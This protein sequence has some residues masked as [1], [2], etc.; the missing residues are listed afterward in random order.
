VIK[1]YD[2]S[3]LVKQAK[4][5]DFGAFEQLVN[6]HETRVYTV[7]MNILRQRQD[8]EDVVQTALLKALE[9]LDGFREEAA[10]STWVR[11]IAVNEALKVL[12][13]RRGQRTVSM[14]KGA[15]ENEE[16]RIPHPGYVACWRGNPAEIVERKNLR[17]ILD[18]AI[19]ALPEK[20]R[21]VFVLRDV[22]GMSVRETAEILGISEPNVKVRLLR[23]RLALR[24][25]L[26]RIFG[27][28]YN[29]VIHDH[30][31]GEGDAPST[32]AED[33]L[34]IYQTR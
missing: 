1:E 26:T 32:A 11:R 3:H 10:F 19:G 7:A 23:A 27:D 20:Q 24:E 5:G 22:E 9:N 16:G 34:R 6:R 2:D 33:L 28:D 13:K 14:E 25:K 18:R 15:L 8:A 30:E 21:L 31:H 12:R 4:A 17:D 29:R